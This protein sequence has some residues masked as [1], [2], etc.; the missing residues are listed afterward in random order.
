[1]L[2]SFQH[3][4]V[5]GETGATI[6]CRDTRCHRSFHLPC[7]MEGG[8]VTQF[9]YQ[10]RYLLCPPHHHRGR[11]QHF[12]PHPSLSSCPQV[13]LL[14]TLPRAGSGG[15]SG[16][17]HHLPHLP[18]AGGGCK[19]PQHPGVPG[20]QA[21]LVSQGLHPGRS[22]SLALGARWTL[23][24]TRASLLLLLFLL[25]GQAVRDGICSFQCPLCR[26]RD[27]FLSEMLIMGIRVPFRF[28]SC[29]PAHKTGGCKRCAMPRAAPARL[30]LCCLVSLSFSLTE[31]L[32]TGRGG[33]AGT[34][35]TCLTP[36]QQGL[37]HF[38]FSIRLPSRDSQADAALSERHSHC[39]ASDCICPGGREQAEE[40]G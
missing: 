3:C 25:Q 27:T 38:S 2:Y 37:I 11:P 15:G 10:Y 28:V 20:V 19:V 34:P 33:R 22:R 12:P 21:R 14:G 4:F 30:A 16:G 24:S 17:E 39:D 35:C 32:E 26:D 8:C 1:M 36:G 23:S 31:E 5:C 6:T 29:C 18:G 40:E 9:L 13:L 7:A